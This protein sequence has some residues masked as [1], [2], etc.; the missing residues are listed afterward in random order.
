[1]TQPQSLKL[2][3]FLSLVKAMRSL[4]WLHKAIWHTRQFWNKT[5]RF[6]L[7]HKPVVDLGPMIEQA[8]LAQKPFAAGKMGS[9]ECAACFHFLKRAK[10]V[11]KGKTPAPYKPY[12]FYTLFLNSGVYPQTEDT[13]DRFAPLYLDAVA[14]CDAL[15]SWDVAGEAEILAR[16]GH[17]T[18]LGLLYSLDACLSP[19]PWTSALRNKKVLVLSPFTES[20]RAQCAR[21]ETLWDN[22][23]TLPAFEL[24]T[25]KTPFSAGLVPPQDAD[26]FAA[27][28]RLKNEMDQL[29]Y[30]VAL[31]GAGAF[32]LPLAAH[33]KSRGKVGLHLGGALQLLFGVYGKRATENGFYKDLIKESWV[34]P[35]AS[36]RPENLKANE[37]GAYW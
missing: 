22:P 7:V 8:I 23:E 21:R 18:T 35:S 2:R 20:I 27:T 24:L 14:H 13:F 17:N 16:F 32:S 37:E 12:I 15:A 29:D 19:H 4:P 34:R 1:M 5:K 11:A 31:I 9:T 6:L 33:A 10:A 36:E 25:I 26:W 28:E 30:D 3:V